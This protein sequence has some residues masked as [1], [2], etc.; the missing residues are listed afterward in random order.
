MPRPKPLI[1]LILDAFG[2]S[3]EHE[4]NPLYTAKKPTFD[5]L[6]QW[7]PFTTLQASGVAVGLPWGEAGNSEVGHLTIGSG[8]VINHHLP[9]IISSIHDG[10]FFENER[11]VKAAEHV[12]AHNSRLHIAGLI[13]SGSVHSYIDHLYALLEF[14]RRQNISE[15]FLHAFADGKDAPPREGKHFFS[16]L[17]LRVQKDW[18]NTK[19]GSI[20][21]RFYAMDREEQ[22][23]RTQKA[24]ELLTQGKGKPCNMLSAHLAQ[25]YTQG[26]TDEFIEPAVMTNDTGE[27]PG[28]IQPNDAVIFINFREDS[29]RQLIEAFARKNFD[30]FP[31]QLVSD[32]FLVTMTDYEKE[33]ANL[34]A[35]P[36]PE[37]RL[38]LAEV[39][40]EA[41]LTHLHIAETN[42]YAHVTYFFNGGRE[43]P[44]AREER[45][46]IISAAVPHPD[47]IPQVKAAEIAAGILGHVETFDVIIANLANA[48]IVGHSGNFDAAVRAV[49]ILDESVNTI[50]TSL[51]NR[52]EGI[53]LVTGDHG[54]IERK[55]HL[56]TGEKRTEHSTNPV[57]LYIV[58]PAFR[59]GAAR[60][61]AEINTIKKEVGGILTDIA[62]TILEILGLHK[63]HEMT[64]T[65]LYPFLLRQLE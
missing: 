59:R 14:T 64:G 43:E 41:G 35:F 8:R 10:S 4:G 34:A 17:A 62:P 9:R 61:E 1:L 57:P 52:N 18:P 47:D 16:E 27:S 55:R 21:G 39:L 32:L 48:D 46:L 15:V 38:P 65:S 42:K 29:M 3:E 26:A 33:F 60:T 31:R 7:F 56:I 24:Y 22:W 6:D 12:R 36:S 25:S 45:M 19:F 20:M 63:P 54:G 50:L 44:F 11:F 37:V 30:R 49:E 58:G 40:G 2:I 5:M 51:M 13:S 28:I 53:M 23:D